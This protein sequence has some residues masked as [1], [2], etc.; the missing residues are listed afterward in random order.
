MI[1]TIK[2]QV[3][4]VTTIS[5]SGN[6]TSPLFQATITYLK[7][8]LENDGP[9]NHPLPQETILSILHCLQRVLQQSSVPD[10]FPISQVTPLS[11]VT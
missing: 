8:K 2:K 7:R 11:Q 9:K 5:V 10:G 3:N 1:Q 6:M 4:D